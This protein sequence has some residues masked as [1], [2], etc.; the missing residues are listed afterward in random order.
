MLLGK[1]IAVII[2]CFQEGKKILNVLSRLSNVPGID[3]IRV[4][5]DGS[6]D[7][8]AQYAVT[9]IYHSKRCGVGAAIRTGLDSISKDYDIAIIMAGN[10]KDDPEEIP[11]LIE[12]L[13]NQEAMLVIGSRYMKGGRAGGE[14]PLYRKLATRLHPFLFSLF[15]GV[16]LTESTNGFRAIDTKLLNDPK[17]HL[18]QTWLD[19]Y[20]LEPYLL[21][22]SIRLGYRWAE[23][24]VTKIYPSKILGY[25][26]MTPLLSWWEILKPLFLLQLRLRR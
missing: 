25:T 24:P 11:K 10:D 5:H 12:A 2:P 4:I 7:S 9:S 22:Q 15:L 26:K 19:G 8:T 18:N 17:I 1:R 23:V 14:M 6:Q 13:V 20:A 3:T 16:K 21:Y